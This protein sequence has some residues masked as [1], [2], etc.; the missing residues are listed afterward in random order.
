MNPYPF[1]RDNIE[2]L[3]DY[4]FALYQWLSQANLDM[5]LLKT[6][7]TKNTFGLLDW[8]MDDGKCLFDGL[9]PGALYRDWDKLERAEKG[10]TFIV[11]TNLGYAVNHVLLNTPDTH[12]VVVLEPNPHM[13]VACLGQTDYRQFFALRKLHFIV[14]DPATLDEVVRNLDLQFVF[15]KIYLREDLPSR[16]MGPEYSRWTKII[17][18]K[19]EN[20]TVEMYTLRAK[21]DVMVGNEL[22]NF[23]QAMRDG[24]L[25]SLKDAAQGVAGVILGAGPSLA[26]FGPKLVQQPGYAMY[27]TALQT[28]PAIQQLGGGAHFCVAIDFNEEMM[29]VYNRLD[30]EWAKNIPLIYSTKVHPEVVRRYPGPTIPLWTQGG[31]GTFLLSERELVLDAGGNVGL[32]LTRLLRWMGVSHLVLVGQDFGWKPGQATHSSGH[33]SDANYGEGI[34]MQ[35]LHGEEIF[36]TIQ[37]LTSKRDLEADLKK[38]P[39]PTYHLYGGGVP[40]EGAIPVDFEQAQ[41]KGLLASAPGARERFLAEMLAAR[42]PKNPPRFEVRAAAWSVSLRNAEKRLEKLLKKPEANQKAVH[43]LLE[44]AIFFVKQDPLYMPY[45]FNEILDLAGLARTRSSYDRPV[46]SEF[47]QLCK[48]VLG[49]VR[50]MD[51]LLNPAINTGANVE[52][53]SAGRKARSAAS[54]RGMAA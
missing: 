38:A 21:Q 22:V 25:N 44:Q 13:L 49:K 4:N 33:H 37:M 34:R 20:Y 23:Q 27:A 50:Q 52:A 36:T 5:E 30:R 24:S 42:R 26:E 28:L 31:V 9:P 16:Q 3:E 15:G 29:A 53:N 39:F 40:I 6:R 48:R 8:R 54:G 18:E 45:L 7:L 17:R 10:A 35:N 43:D 32:T 1:L 51:R 47:K 11:G 41:V 46:L 2:A 19:M 14:P 12:K